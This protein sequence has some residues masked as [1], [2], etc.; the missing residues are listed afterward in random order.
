MKKKKKDLCLHSNHICIDVTPMF[1]ISSCCSFRLQESQLELAKW[2]QVLR[3]AT[4]E[5]AL[6]GVM[7]FKGL[8]SRKSVE[9]TISLQG[10]LTLVDG[11]DKV[12]TRSI[13]ISTIMC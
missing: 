12:R 2:I 10:Q 8:W 6:D 4:V 13:K 3:Q 7:V 11:Q 9:L 5:A 1:T